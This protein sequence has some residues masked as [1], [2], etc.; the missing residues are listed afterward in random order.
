MKQVF[1]LKNNE[2]QFA[3]MPRASNK[4]IGHPCLNDALFRK[5]TGLSILQHFTLQIL[6]V[7][8]LDCNS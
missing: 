8:G 2:V 1:F 5:G 3:I 6:Y 4:E 7:I